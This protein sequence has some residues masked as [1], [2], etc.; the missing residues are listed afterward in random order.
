MDKNLEDII[1]L[2]LK[3]NRK[4]Q[5][6]LYQWCYP[7]LMRICV[8]Y[9][10]NTDDAVALLND[11]FLKIL[12]GLESYDKNRSFISWINTLMIRTAIDLYRKERKHIDNLHYLDEDRSMEELPQAV[13]N[14][15]LE[16]LDEDEILG[17]INNL[18]ETEK[19]VFNLFEIDGY[20][21]NDIAEML[22]IS[23]RTSKRYL[24]RAKQ[25]LIGALEKKTSFK[26]V[27]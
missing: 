25:L 20:S 12:L 9:Q 2:C 3:N 21:H 19:Q 16:K 27:V 8:R 5:Y 18:P 13:S 11:G 4:A 23:E 17:M 10:R 22:N 7:F 26:K 6:D 24:H 15:L 14:E 1:Q